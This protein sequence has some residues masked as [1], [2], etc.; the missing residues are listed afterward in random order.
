MGITGTWEG[1]VPTATDL[2]LRGNNIASWTITRGSGRFDSGQI[3]FYIPDVTPFKYSGI[4]TIKTGQSYNISGYTKINIQVKDLMV[5]SNLKPYI[6][7]VCGG[8]NLGSIIINSDQIYTQTFSFDI[9]KWDM[10][11]EITFEVYTYSD[12]NGWSGSKGIIYH[13]WLS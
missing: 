2:Y 3:S 13:I 4:F 8:Q 11:G 6:H 1:Y 7:F 10:T 9:S 5:R 12:Q